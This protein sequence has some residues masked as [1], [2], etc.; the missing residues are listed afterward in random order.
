[1]TLFMREPP[2]GG[3]PWGTR[4]NWTLTNLFI[5][6]CLCCLVWGNSLFEK[7]KY[8][9]VFTAVCKMGVLPFYQFLKNY[10]TAF[11]GECTDS[12]NLTLAMLDK[13]NYRI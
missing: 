7:S 10:L 6:S 13:T 2:C 9:L 8:M 4:Q 12:E 3:F 11:M 5:N 1:M